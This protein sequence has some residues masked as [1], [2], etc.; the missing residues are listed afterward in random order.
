MIVALGL[1]GP[2]KNIVEK[3]VL[4]PAGKLLGF[5]ALTIGAGVAATRMTITAA[6]DLAAAIPDGSAGVVASEASAV[7]TELLGFLNYVQQFPPAAYAI[8]CCAFDILGQVLIGLMLPLSICVSVWIYAAVLGMI[9]K[10]RQ[11]LFV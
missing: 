10:L 3:W 5:F 4:G 2:F 11:A 7:S 9:R 1:W 8:D 6:A